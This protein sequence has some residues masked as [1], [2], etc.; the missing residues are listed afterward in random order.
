MSGSFRR[1]D[2]RLRS[3]KGVER[4]MMGEAFLRLERF[5]DIKT[6][7]YVGMGSV[8][9]SDFAVF[10][11]V[12]GFETMISIENVT[13]LA[14]K[15][16]FRFNVPFGDIELH[17]DH[18]NAALPSLRW[19]LRTV[20][21]LDYDDM[22]SA[23]MLTDIR[24]LATQLV[25]G[26][27]LAVTVRGDLR[28]EDQGVSTPRDVLAG[29]V[30]ES[31][32]PNSVMMAGHVKPDEMPQTIREILMQEVKDGVN[33]R[34]SGRPRGQSYAFEQIMFF[35]YRDGCPMVTLCW[36]LFEEGQR[37]TFNS[38]GFE[39]LLCFRKSASPFSI[40]IPFVTNAEIRAIN[41]CGIGSTAP[42]ITDLPIPPTEIAKY[43]LLRRY[44]PLFSNPELT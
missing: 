19:D 17:F 41:Q 2:Y 6:Y 11:S 38:C 4:R 26:S 8:Y 24:Y 20:I 27:A 7:R 3:A 42:K 21:W 16:R 5:G 28:D 44:W 12:C 32:I 13:D 25:P 35:K 15:R 14:E 9:F 18:T 37:P 36:V 30:G 40:K 22:I 34:N 29:R 43:Q 31:K 33:D 39:N 23:D 1:V 10:H